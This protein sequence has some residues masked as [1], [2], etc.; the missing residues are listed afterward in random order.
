MDRKGFHMGEGLF[1]YLN[2]EYVKNISLRIF[3][4]WEKRFLIAYPTAD[5][6]PEMRDSSSP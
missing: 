5:R 6:R 2:M 3:F 1:M 4:S